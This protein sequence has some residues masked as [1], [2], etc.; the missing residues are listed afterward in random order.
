MVETDMRRY[1][2]IDTHSCKAAKSKTRP[3]AEGDMV[4]AY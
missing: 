1:V 2:F 4:G 3:V